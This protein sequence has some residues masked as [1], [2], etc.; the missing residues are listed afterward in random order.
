M[1]GGLSHF[2]LLFLSIE[3][4]EILYTNLLLWTTEVK[5]TISAYS[6]RLL[7]LLRL[8]SFLEILVC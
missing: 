5:S 4:I 8:L 1:G 7:E 2:S 6:S 3:L